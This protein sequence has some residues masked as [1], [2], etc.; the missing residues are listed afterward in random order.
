MDLPS[1][2]SRRMKLFSLRM[3]F[4]FVALITRVV[5]RVS[6]VW[7]N[8]FIKK[9]VSDNTIYTSNVRPFLVKSVFFGIFV[10]GI[11]GGAV[12]QVTYQDG[13]VHVSAGVPTAYA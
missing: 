13:G 1:Q 9:S 3:S 4:S 10:L 8:L 12:P 11:I 5:S 2:R 7:K 6:I